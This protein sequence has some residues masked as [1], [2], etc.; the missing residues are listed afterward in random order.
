MAVRSFDIQLLLRPN[1]LVVAGLDS[2]IRCRRYQAEIRNIAPIKGN[3]R[4]DTFSAASAV[5][6][7]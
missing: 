5:V 2:L 3:F 7:I 4:A 6:Q 1:H